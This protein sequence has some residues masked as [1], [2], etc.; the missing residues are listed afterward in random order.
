MKEKKQKPTTSKKSSH[1]TL[2]W[3]EKQLRDVVTFDIGR[4]LNK[5]RLYLRLSI[6]TRIGIV[7]NFLIHDT[8]NI[9]WSKSYS[10]ES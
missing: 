9:R 6:I 8:T 4:S 2:D 1:K 3:V 10:Y 5:E 7:E